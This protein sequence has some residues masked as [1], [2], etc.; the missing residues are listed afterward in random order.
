MLSSEA[1]TRAYS[2][3]HMGKESTRRRRGRDDKRERRADQHLEAHPSCAEGGETERKN[4]RG[5]SS[6]APGERRQLRQRRRRRRKHTR[7]HARTHRG[8]KRAESK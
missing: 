5:K 4:E 8:E 7:A 2:S 6:A 3:T 1:L